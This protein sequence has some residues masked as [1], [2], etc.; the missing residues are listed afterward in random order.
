MSET[1]E[2]TKKVVAPS[3]NKVTI[4]LEEYD[5]LKEQASKP[6][7]V[8]YRVVRKTDEQNATDNMTFG[9][10][11]VLVGLAL[12]VGGTILFKHGKKGTNTSS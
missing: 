7:K 10:V 9:V 12:S 3:K 6:T 8:N 2:T 11:M 1:T 4:S 5:G